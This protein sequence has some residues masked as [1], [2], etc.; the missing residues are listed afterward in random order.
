MG[1]DGRVAALDLADAGLMGEFPPELGNLARLRFLNL[2]SRVRRANILAGDL[3]AEWDNLTDLE[4]MYLGGTELTG[5]MGQCLPN[6]VLQ[7]QLMVT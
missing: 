2:E 5:R 3:P 1:A 4:V 7:L 6:L